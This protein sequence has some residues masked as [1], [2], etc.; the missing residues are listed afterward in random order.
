[1]KKPKWAKKL[2]VNHLKHIAEASA[3][4][5][6][7]LRVA[8]LNANNDLCVICKNIGNILSINGVI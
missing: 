6:P 5:R 1:M 7:S 8:K 3:T 2:T 4:G